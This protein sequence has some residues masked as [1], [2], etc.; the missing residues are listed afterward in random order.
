MPRA[1]LEGMLRE[2]AKAGLTNGAQA[3]LSAIDRISEVLKQKVDVQQRAD[4][5]P[6]VARLKPLAAFFREVVPESAGEGSGVADES[7]SEGTANA[8]STAVLA[9][10]GDIR[11]RED[12]T[13]MLDKICEYLER[14]EPTNPAP[15]LIRRAQKLMTM[16]FVDILKEVAPEGVASVS[17]IAGLPGEGQ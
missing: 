6:L 3:A 2:A 12:V 10:P 13:R 1:Q 4:L 9:P 7:P 8:S 5:R 11:N 17:K 16:S 14:S 15:L